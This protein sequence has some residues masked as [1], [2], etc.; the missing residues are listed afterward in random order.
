LAASDSIKPDIIFTDLYMPDISGLSVVKDLKQNERLKKTPVII[1]SS[2]VAEKERE[3]SFL[4]GCDDFLSKPIIEHDLLSLIDA[5]LKPSWT[6]FDTITEDLPSLTDMPFPPI[7]H[8]REL[9]TYAN[10]G[11]LKKIEMY[12]E[13]IPSEF[14]DFKS[15]IRNQCLSYNIKQM[16]DILNNKYGE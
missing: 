7:E 16:K 9:L 1:M 14:I 5:F 8:V 2:T 11:N 13:N 15:M 3:E 10:Q 4:A 6:F 12:L